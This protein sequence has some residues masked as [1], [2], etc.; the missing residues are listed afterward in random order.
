MS[1]K[2]KKRIILKRTAGNN[3]FTI[4]WRRRKEAPI[5]PRMTK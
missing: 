5:H 3:S 2:K 1:E 4:A